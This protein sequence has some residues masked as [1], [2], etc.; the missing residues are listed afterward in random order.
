MH[1]IVIGG[2][3]VYTDGDIINCDIGI[4]GER[5]SRIGKKLAGEKVINAEGRLILPGA[6]DCH[7]HF[8]D[9][10]EK[11]KETWETGSRA[12]LRGGTVVVIDQPNTDPLT[13]NAGIF[14]KRV[15]LAGKS[16][17]VD[18]RVNMALT[19][20]NFP[21]IQKI[22]EEVNPNAI[23]EVFLQHTEEDLQI[24]FEILF[25]VRKKVEGIIT[26]HA[27]DPGKITDGKEEN[28]KLRPPEAE[29][30]AIEKCRKHG[31]F[32]FCHVSLGSSLELALSEESQVEVTPHHLLLSTE[33]ADSIMFNVNPPLR[34]ENERRTLISRL[35]DIDVFA[36]DHAPHTLEE[37]KD[38]APGFPNV[39][40]MYPL[41]LDMA[42]RGVFPLRKLIE[43]ISENPARIF[44][45][46]G[47]GGIKEGNY[48]SLAIFDLKN[49]SEIRSEDMYTMAEWTPFEGFSAI[50]PEKV[51]LRGKLAFDNGE[52]LVKRGSGIKI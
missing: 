2:G 39:E 11:Y 34:S 4:D 17:F 49:V 40:L 16:S 28:W 7:V 23:G 47:Y 48:A 35:S 15:E 10:R 43:R 52:V 18:F 1:E 50:F 19:R 9:F 12:A 8:R 33:D 32:Y 20:K 27:E 45:I 22:C 29:I 3:H 6:I 13:Q 14:R 5:I 26:V 37:K 51:F 25:E 31:D 38:G 21:D 30:M 41:L 36:S 42:T 24:P 44:N 46:D